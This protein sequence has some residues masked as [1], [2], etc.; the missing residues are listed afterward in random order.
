MVRHRQDCLTQPIIQPK[1]GQCKAVAGCKVRSTAQTTL[2]QSENWCAGSDAAV[3]RRT[4]ARRATQKQPTVHY[5][6]YFSV[7][8]YYTFLLFAVFGK[9]MEV[10][11]QYGWGRSLLLTFPGFFSFGVFSKQGPTQKQMEGTTFQMDFFGEGYSKGTEP[12]CFAD[13]PLLWSI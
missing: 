12:F 9:M 11:A 10:L 6:A 2:S 3:V 13:L 1:H 8:S 5:G 7:K 4:Q